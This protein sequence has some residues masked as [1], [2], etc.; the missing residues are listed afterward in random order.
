MSFCPFDA[1]SA[2]FHHEHGT[3][4]IFVEQTSAIDMSD[5]KRAKKEKKKKAEETELRKSDE[6]YS[7]QSGGETP[8]RRDSDSEPLV[9]VVLPRIKEW[10]GLPGRAGDDNG[11]VGF[12]IDKD[13]VQNWPEIAVN[14]DSYPTGMIP[15]V[16][17]NMVTTAKDDRDMRL[18]VS[19]LGFPMRGNH[20]TK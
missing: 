19:S 4:K 18:F 5:K 10:G 14:A 20:P 3:E 15:T 8:T 12:R 6:F 2:Q 1:M 9:D 16:Q 13:V 11:N 7:A 17:V